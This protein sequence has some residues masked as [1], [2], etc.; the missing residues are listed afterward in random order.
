MKERSRKSAG[1]KSKASR[2]A[3][4]LQEFSGGPSPSNSQAGQQL[5]LFGLP[6]APAPRSRQQ[7]K[8]K[9]VQSA[10]VRT[11]SRALDELATSFAASAGTPGSPTSGTCGPRYGGSSASAVLGQ[12]LESR[13]V[14][15]MEGFGSPEF[16]LHWRCLGMP[17]GP[18]ILQRAASGRHTSD[19]GCSGWPSPAAN[20][21]EPTNLNVMEQRRQK[22][23]EKHGNNGFGLTLGMASY[24]AGWPSPD[25]S[26]HGSYKSPEKSLETDLPTVAEMAGWPTTTAR[27][28]RDGRSN[29]HGKNA[30]PLNEVAELAGWDT[31]TVADADKVTAASNRGLMRQTTGPTPS[32]STAET[33]KRDES[34]GVLN[35]FFSA[36][37]MGFPLSWTLAGL[38][39]VSRSRGKSRD[40][41]RS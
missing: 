10:V 27:D 41:L 11:L 37:L 21:Y 7:G 8:R 36:W 38:R 1:K 18:R 31:P 39:A 22:C 29:Q 26:H 40:G 19:K 25:H 5:D 30:R 28:F 34:R 35:P 4:G 12:L 6:V 9:P 23:A 3:T 2:N 13:L 17:L 24:L 16:A 20:E 32:S 15:V 33:A 14:D